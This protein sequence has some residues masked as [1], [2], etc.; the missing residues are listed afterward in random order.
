MIRVA[1]V[2]TRFTA[3]A[4]GVA[5]QG[6]LALDASRFEVT[7]L[8]A[9]GGSLI[10][11]AQRAGLE[12]IGLQHMR[13][14]ISP[15]DD[16]AALHELTAH[17]RDR[18]FDVVH[19][20]SSKAGAL[21]RVAGRW[22]QTP[23]LVH[24]FHGFP[25]HPFQSRVRRAAYVAVER[26]L[27][28]LTD[29]FLAVGIAVAA[30]AVRLG[31][32]PPD[33]I[34]AITSVMNHGVQRATRE[35]RTRARALMGVPTEAK[36]VG[37]I[38]RIDYQ[39]APEDMAEAVARVQ[40][41]DAVF[42]WIGDGPLRGRLEKRIRQLH[43]EDHFLLLGERKDVADLLPGLDVFALASLYEGLPCA[44]VEA[45]TCGV[46]VV[47]TAVNAVPELVIPG[48]T[49]I[50]VPAATP[51]L[52]AQ[53]IAHLLANPAEAASMASAAR[54]LVASGFDAQRL[55]RDLA[56]VYDRVLAGK[57]SRREPVS[58]AL[59]LDAA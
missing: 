44:L 13:P 10:E 15:R 4:G 35:S 33:R 18:R 58:P 52:L 1:Q 47:A 12:V 14:D 39:K 43:L 22:A 32:A 7:I 57:E 16:R 46:P 53:G 11:S 8:T 38:G 21:G 55:G 3:G 24:T 40:R 26:R 5:L 30:D 25:F 17:L 9:P 49:G 36:V 42:V 45:M 56:E 37:T 51:R 29:F 19:T 23:C 59:A 28:R 34:R 6:A 27:G 31:I 2:I 50:L 48:R 54:R 20:H 41:R